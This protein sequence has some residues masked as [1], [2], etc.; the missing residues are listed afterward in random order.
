MGSKLAGW[1]HVQ[2]SGQQISILMDTSDK[3]CPSGAHTGTSVTIIFINDMDEGVQ[4]ILSKSADDTKLS[5]PA[6]TPE[7][8]DATQRDLDKPEK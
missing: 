2:A 7:G 1:S 3:R 4:C 5:D 8:Q 6:G